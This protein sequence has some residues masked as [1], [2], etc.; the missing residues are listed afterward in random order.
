MNNNNN[1]N[2][3][4][5]FG[6]NDGNYSKNEKEKE[7]E[8]NINKTIKMRKILE[9]LD[10]KNL[11]PITLN[12]PESLIDRILSSLFF[13]YSNN[14][15]AY[16]DNNKNYHVKFSPKQG[17]IESTSFDF[18]NKKPAFVIYNE[19]SINRDM[20]SNG[21]KLSMVSEVN[22]LHFGQFIDIS[23]LQKKIKQL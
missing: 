22:S 12:P 9:L 16:A 1:N 13:G 8:K 2:N 7:K 11:Q 17:S 19:F 15:A 4:N 6:G 14:L 5:M 3:N 23:E 20:G 10:I 21:S 18:S